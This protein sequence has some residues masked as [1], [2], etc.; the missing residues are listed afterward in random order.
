[1]EAFISVCEKANIGVTILRDI[2]GTCCGQIFSSKGFAEAHRYTA[3][4]LMDQLWSSSKEGALP[5]VM[6]V[7]SCAYTLKKMRH[8]LT[9]D[10]Q[11]RYDKLV[12]FDSVE[13]LHDRVIPVVH[14]RTMKEQIV[15]HPVCSLEKMKTTDKFL[16]IARHFARSVTIPKHAGCCGMAG[17]RGFLFPELTASATQAEA[18]EVRQHDYDGYYSTTRTCELAMS[19]AVRKNYESI[20]YLVDEAL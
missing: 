5:I 10:K 11:E 1:M 19:E 8:A 6:D 2:E 7:S 15:L 14:A 17:D 12:I 9:S 3:N 13:F 4:R 16:A 20:L 18:S